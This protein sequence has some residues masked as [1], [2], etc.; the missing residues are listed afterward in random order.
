MIL[1]L[2]GIWIGAAITTLINSICATFA[3]INFMQFIIRI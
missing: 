3:E 1:T 2:D